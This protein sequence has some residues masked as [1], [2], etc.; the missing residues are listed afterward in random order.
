MKHN[1]IQCRGPGAGFVLAKI[2]W[3]VGGGRRRP[4]SVLGQNLCGNSE[5]TKPLKNM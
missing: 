1:G 3:G 2:H 4:A 5:R